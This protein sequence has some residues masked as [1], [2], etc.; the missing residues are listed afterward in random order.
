MVQV[1]SIEADLSMNEWLKWL[2]HSLQVTIKT[3]WLCPSFSRS[4]LPPSILVGFPHMH[5]V[6]IVGRTKPVKTLPT[7]AA[8]LPQPVL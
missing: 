3:K 6:L 5:V 8:K 7:P 2:C 1:G 4:P